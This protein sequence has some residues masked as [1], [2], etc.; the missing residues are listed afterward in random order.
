MTPRERFVAVMQFEP[1]VR[2]LKAEYGYWTTAMKRFVQEGMPV[3]EALPAALPDNG[4]ITGA[5]KVDPNGSEIPDRNVRAALRLEPYPAKFPFTMSPLL[6]E[7]TLEESEEYRVY[8]DQYGITMKVYKKGASAPLDLDFPI[9]SRRDFEHYKELYDGNFARRLPRDWDRLKGELRARD[10][11]IRLG[12]FPYGFFGF[13]RHLIGTTQILLMMYDD[14]GLIKSMNDFFLD[15]AMEY[16]SFIIR[17]IDP[18]CVLIWEDMA[19]KTGSMISRAMFAEFLEP[20]YIRMIDYLHEMGIR[21]IHVDSDGYVEELIPLW[22]RLGVTGIF[23][24]EIQAGNDPL[25]VRERFPGLQLLGGIDKRVFTS[26]HTTADIDRELAK[27][28]Q[29]LTQGG[30]IPHADHHVPDDACWENFSYYRRELNRLIDQ[31]APQ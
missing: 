3:T 22:V 17:E 10:Y 9:K 30:F 26:A 24:L 16:W 31:S 14:P 28:P 11:A 19:S 12:G 7:K 15:F 20:W 25:R 6:P 5:E 29:L 8:T 4:T 23:P 27:V 21:N 13:P 1:G 2:T 18:D